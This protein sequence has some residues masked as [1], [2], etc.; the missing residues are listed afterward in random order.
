MK[1]EAATAHGREATEELLARFRL[2]DRRACARLMSFVEDED[3]RATRVLDELYPSRGRAWRVGVTG[4]PG[5][6]KSTLVEKL[7][8]ELRSRGRTVGIIA[9]DPTSP[10]SG[11]AILGDR[12]RMPRL[13]TDE[14][15]FI[16]S[17]ASRGGLGGL[18]RRTREVCDVLDAFG[19]EVIIIETVGVGQIELDVASAAHTTV[20]VLVPESGDSV[21]VMKAGLMEIGEIFCINKADR[22][23]AERL[24]VE[25]RSM[26]DLLPDG[27]EWRPPVVETVATAGEGVVPLLDRLEEHRQFLGESGRL[28]ELRRRQ[29]RTEIVEI[30]EER[31]R[32]DVW[33]RQRISGRLAEEVEAVL[34]GGATPYSAAGRVLGLVRPGD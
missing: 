34:A 7:A 18:A 21:Q 29:V 1:P 24:L 28:E 3:D 16:R 11:G 23:G 26:L 32:R 4:P 9:V 20:V 13:F 27:R 30:V 14:G 6:G 31:L 5:A 17:M 15:V 25:V 19:S 22:Q 12:V 33:R 2:G 10:F 8:R